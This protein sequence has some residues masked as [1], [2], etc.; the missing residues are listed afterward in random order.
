ML[1]PATNVLH[2]VF[3]VEL[4]FCVSLNTKQIISEAFF[5]LPLSWLGIE[6]LNLTQ[7]KHTFTNHKKCTTTQNM[8]KK[9]KAGLSCL[10]RHPAWK[11]RG[12]ILVLMLHN[13]SLTY[14][15]PWDPQRHHF[16]NMA[17]AFYAFIP[18]YSTVKTGDAFV[19]PMQRFVDA[20]AIF[21]K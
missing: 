10:L 21:S 4:R 5:P 14:L 20:V 12:P 7:Q 6:K 13:L 9:T 8:H 2:R 18:F 1:Q 19:S 17:T 15:Q 16:E 3:P 11:R